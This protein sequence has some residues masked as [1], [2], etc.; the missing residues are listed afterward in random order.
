MS[1]TNVRTAHGDLAPAA[2]SRVRGLAWV[3]IVAHV[4]FVAAWL[5]A[6]AWQVPAYSAAAHS[7]SDMYAYGA[8][9]AAFLIVVTTACGVAGLLFVTLSLWP[10][11]RAAGVSARVGCALLALSVLGVGD[12]L[13]PLERV[14]CQRADPECSATD[15]LANLGGTLDNAITS[16][17]VVALV[18]SAFVIAAAMKRLPLWAAWARPTRWYG[19]VLFLLFVATPLSDSSGLSGLFERFV[20]AFAAAG[21]VALGVGVLR[22]TPRPT[23]RLSAAG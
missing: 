2:R 8:P 4:V 6:A 12:L 11:L 22:T 16:V 1:E 5:V 21:V 17:G 18:A 7:I 10:S 15:Q 3:V 20:A 23:A 9:H 19:L 13:T 14:A